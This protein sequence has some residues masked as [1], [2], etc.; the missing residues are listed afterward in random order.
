MADCPPL[1]VSR[2][3]RPPAPPA[4]TGVSSVRK[5]LLDFLRCVFARLALRRSLGLAAEMA[6]WLFL[7]LLPLSAVA[8]L[9]T[10]KL[11]SGN[12]SIA[13]LLLDSL[14][15]ATREMVLYLFCLV[16][17]VGMTVNEM[18]GQRRQAIAAPEETGAKHQ[19]PP[20]GP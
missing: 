5:R 12:A 4:G 10:A 1:P 15:R 11:A 9:V 6:F 7:S 20:D 13:A 17:L 18:L 3:R 8:G 2:S 19:S 14:P 16:L